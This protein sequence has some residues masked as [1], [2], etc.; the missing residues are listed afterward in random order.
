MWLWSSNCF[1]ILLFAVM[2]RVARVC[3][4]QL[5]YFVCHDVARIDRLIAYL[6][7]EFDDIFTFFDYRLFSKN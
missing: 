5:S 2:Q 6:C 1:K 7:I 3:Q 4:R